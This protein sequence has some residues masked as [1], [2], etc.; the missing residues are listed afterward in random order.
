MKNLKVRGL[1]INSIIEVSTDATYQDVLDIYSATRDVDIR[2]YDIYAGRKKI[3]DKSEQVSEHELLVMK[4]K[5][6][7]N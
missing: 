7:G 4:G 5:H 3:T 1:G 2:G 6:E